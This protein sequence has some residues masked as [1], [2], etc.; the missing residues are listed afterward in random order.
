MIHFIMTIKLSE[1]GEIRTLAILEFSRVFL[2][3]QE[4][5]GNSVNDF[6]AR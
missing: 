1:L 3:T 5:Q 6:V 2:G 4:A